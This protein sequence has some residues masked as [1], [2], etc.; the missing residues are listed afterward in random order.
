LRANTREPK[1]RQTATLLSIISVLAELFRHLPLFVASIHFLQSP[2]KTKQLVFLVVARGKIAGI[3]REFG[4]AFAARMREERSIVHVVP[5]FVGSTVQRRWWLDRWSVWCR[6]ATI[7]TCLFRSLPAAG[8][9]LC[10]FEFVVGCSNGTVLLF[11]SL[12]RYAAA[13]LVSFARLSRPHS[14]TVSTACS[15]L[16]AF[17]SHATA[18]SFQNPPCCGT[19]SLLSAAFFFLCRIGR[20]IRRPLLFIILLLIVA[21]TLCYYL[22]FNSICSSPFDL[23]YKHR[24]DHGAFYGFSTRSTRYRT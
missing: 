14:S 10:C 11:A 24:Q 12:V 9:S 23:F 6:A 2:S 21:H 3:R 7:I 4:F 8:Y 17:S 18:L 15:N 19:C 16:L 1:K 20:P 13:D 5:L 22:H